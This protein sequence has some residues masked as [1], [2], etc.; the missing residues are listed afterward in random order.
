MDQ[1][2]QYIISNGINTEE[3]YP[4]TATGPNACRFNKSNVAAMLKSYE[5]CPT[6]D[7]A[8]LL[9]FVVSGPTSVGIDSSVESFQL[10]SSGIYYEPKCSS[11]SLDHG[12]L[13]VGYGSSGSGDYWLVKNSWGE[14]WGMG[15][16]ILMSRNRGNNCGI[17]SAA[18]LPRT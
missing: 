10:Y 14:D 16:Y 12:V 15:G 2:F 13:V 5:E 11:T 8:T 17:A 9:K 7:E 1:A 4:Y 18:S 3:S 6:G